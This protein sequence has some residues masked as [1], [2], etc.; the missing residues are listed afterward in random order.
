MNLVFSFLEDWRTSYFLNLVVS[1]TVT[2]IVDELKN[3]YNCGLNG[4]FF[5]KTCFSPFLLKKPKELVQ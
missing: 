3:I 2:I 1:T 4:C 5:F